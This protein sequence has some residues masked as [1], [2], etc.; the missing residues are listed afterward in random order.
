MTVSKLNLE[1]GNSGEDIA[2]DLLRRN[3]YRIITRNFRTKSGEIDIIA[4][5]ADTICFV[6][7]KTR[8][9][10]KVG[11][12]EESVTPKK[13]RHASRAALLFLKNHNLL[14]KRARFDVVSVLLSE[15]KKESKLIK[16]A[17]ALEEGYSY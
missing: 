3:G 15:E 5:E 8:Q 16:N 12:P 17:F 6:E 9:S 2:V 11:F 1:L 13:Q 14:G 7:V 4:W 10:L